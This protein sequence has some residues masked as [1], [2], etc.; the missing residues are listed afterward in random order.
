MTTPEALIAAAGQYTDPLIGRSLLQAAVPIEWVS[1]GGA[2][3][4]RVTLGFPCAG[5]LQTFVDA[6]RAH[7][8]R[9]RVP[10]ADSLPIEV[11]SRVEPARAGG[12]AVAGVKNLIAVA[13][14]KGGVGKSTVAVNLALALAAEG[15][16]TGLLD[17]DV[18]G[19]SQPRMLGIAQRP[20][21]PDG[22]KLEPLR[23]Y[24]LQAM[25]IGFLVDPRQPV[26]WR[27][28][29]ATQA[30]TQLLGQTEWQGL[31][32]LVLDLPPGTGDI[33]LSLAQRAPISGAVVVTTPQAVALEPAR[34]GLEMF[35]KV[36][37][38]ILGIVEN[39][40]A[41]VCPQC[42]H[43]EAVFG[44]GG[45][46]RLAAETGSA[47]LGQIPLDPRIQS[48]ADEGRPTVVAEPDSAITAHY[49]DIA[50]RATARLAYGVT[51]AELPHIEIADD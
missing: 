13:S 46:A 44:A 5:Y 32:Y 8:V 27:G 25:S 2:P 23:A 37:V 33:Q 29:M 28:P 38:P 40:S 4:L 47:L 24:G 45:G 15:A 16:A 41:Y 12:E 22:R 36:S 35:V 17:A 9:Q 10:A 42:G 7:L 1:S 49:R 11:M 18:Y 39:M 3:R 30:L 26:V 31:D 34:K 51:P 48:Q 21:S 6:L 19:P 14:G 50:R 20:S 43:H